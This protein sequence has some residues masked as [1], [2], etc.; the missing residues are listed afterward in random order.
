MIRNYHWSTLLA[1]TK[2]KTKKQTHT[3]PILVHRI[4][5]VAWHYKKSNN[6]RKLPASHFTPSSLF[7]YISSCDDIT[8]INIGTFYVSSIRIRKKKSDIY[9]LKS[10]LNV[11]D[12][13]SIKLSKVVSFLRNLR[14]IQLPGW[15]LAS[16]LAKLWSTTT[17][18]A[19]L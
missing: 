18:I 17:Q 5:P 15:R 11:A 4:I 3:E 8:K 16:K 6:E 1:M 10:L 2:T 9:F 19:M 7:S 14:T 12:I 13:S